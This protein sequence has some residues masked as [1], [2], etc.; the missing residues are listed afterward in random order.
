MEE[1]NTA[2]LESVVFFSVWVR[3]Y[4]TNELFVQYGHIA[5]PENLN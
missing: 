4:V 1:L 3:E 2:P 5:I